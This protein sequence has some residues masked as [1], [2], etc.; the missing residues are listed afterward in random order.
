MFWYL[1]LVCW[2][3]CLF[4]FPPHPTPRVFENYLVL[5]LDH[6]S[7]LNQA[8][9][10]ASGSC[11]KH[12]GDAKAIWARVCWLVQNVSALSTVCL[13][14]AGSGDITKNKTQRAQR[15][16]PYNMAGDETDVS[17][18]RGPERTLSAFPGQASWRGWCL[19][20]VHRSSQVQSPRRE[21]WGPQL[22]CSLGSPFQSSL[23]F[24][25]VLLCSSFSP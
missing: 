9:G 13:H 12:A 6:F 16:C 10:H 21:G 15:R 24:L 2:P 11:L 4:C 20:W 5:L 18:R 23:T 3:F 25:L 19:S 22:G 8:L 17:T 1:L 7:V 14:C